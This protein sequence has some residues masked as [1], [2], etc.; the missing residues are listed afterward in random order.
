MNRDVPPTDQGENINV[1]A[2][3]WSECPAVGQTKGTFKER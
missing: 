2:G 1:T 3:M